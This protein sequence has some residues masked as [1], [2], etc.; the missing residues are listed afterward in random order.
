MTQF[1]GISLSSVDAV[2]LYTFRYASPFLAPTP[3]A[4]LALVSQG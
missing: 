1:V 3:G 4:V 2:T